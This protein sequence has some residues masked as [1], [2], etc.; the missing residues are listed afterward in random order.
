[1]MIVNKKKMIIAK[2]KLITVKKRKRKQSRKKQSLLIGVYLCKANYHTLLITYLE[3]TIKNA[4]HAW[5]E[6]NPSQYAIL[7]GLKIID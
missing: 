6:K 2:K 4:N 1:M 5:K 7:L 3:L